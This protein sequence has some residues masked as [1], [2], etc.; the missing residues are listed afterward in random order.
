MTVDT[1]EKWYLLDFLPPPSATPN[2]DSVYLFHMFFKA[3]FCMS[4]FLEINNKKKDFVT[5][6]PPIHLFYVG[7][8]VGQF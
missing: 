6:F 8:S 4:T 1:K 5:T 2:K 7:I 3:L